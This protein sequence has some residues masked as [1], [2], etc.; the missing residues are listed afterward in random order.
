MRPS[1]SIRLCLMYQHLRAP[2]HAP[3]PLLGPLQVQSLYPTLWFREES[4]LQLPPLIPVEDHHHILG[5]QV[6]L[7]KP[8]EEPSKELLGLGVRGLPPTMDPLEELEDLQVKAASSRDILVNLEVQD[9]LVEAML[10]F[11]EDLQHLGALNMGVNPV[12]VRVVTPTH[13]SRRCWLINVCE[14]GVNGYYKHFF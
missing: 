13:P 8:L 3:H 10:A 9:I 1:Q 4:N 5:A 12:K 11:L 14:V 6:Q 2:P 7:T